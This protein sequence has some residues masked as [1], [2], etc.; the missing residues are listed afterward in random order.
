MSQPILSGLYFYPVKSLRGIPL[1][2]APVDA[3]G[4]HFDRHWMVVDGA[5]K[6]ITQRQYPRMA[7]VHTALTPGGLRL[8]APGMPD[9]EV[10][11][12][13]ETVQE[14]QVQVWG[15]S[16]LARSAGDPPATWLSRFLGTPC[17]L[18]YMPEQ[19]ERAVD[20][21]YATARDRVGFADGFPFLL[22]SQASLDDLNGRLDEALPM[23][24]FRPNLVV[25]GSA[26]Y[27][28]DQWRRIRIGGLTFRVAKPCSRCVI[29]TINPQTGEKGVEPLRTLNRY[30]RDGNKVYFGQNL[31]H[32]G[33]GELKL[34]MTV[35]LL[36]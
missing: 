16:C 8:S 17:R 5:G 10:A 22:I 9:L 18:F 25:S 1:E 30:R 20:S 23:I 3:R 32:D 2:R 19:T 14:E 7:L 4:I 21:R 27:A 24:R 28:E 34:G 35:E 26:P 31:L 13:P 6:F 33:T 12:E 11:F 15:D 29:P 36:E